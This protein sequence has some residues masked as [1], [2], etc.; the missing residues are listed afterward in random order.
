MAWRTERLRREIGGFMRQYQRKAHPGMDPNDRSYDRKFEER[1]K[2]LP[3]EELD[4]L[5]NGDPD[6]DALDDN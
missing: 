1:L 6:E 3:P 2:R 4:R 5:L